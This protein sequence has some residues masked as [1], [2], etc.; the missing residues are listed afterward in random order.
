MTAVRIDY[1]AR[2]NFVYWFYDASG[3]VL[4]IGC[5]CRPEKR[6]QRHRNTNPDLIAETSRC[7][8]QGPYQRIVALAIETKAINTERPKYNR[9]WRKAA[10]S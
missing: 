1:W 3:R 4:Y 7:R 8:M 10:I 5:T 6:W 2:N 9:R